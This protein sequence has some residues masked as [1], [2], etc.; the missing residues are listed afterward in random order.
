[1]PGIS[2]AVARN[3]IIPFLGNKS[4]PQVS[5]IE[6]IVSKHNQFTRSGNNL[7][8]M[9]VSRQLKLTEISNKGENNGNYPNV[10]IPK[11]LSL[12]PSLAMDWLEISWDELEMKERVGAGIFFP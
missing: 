5:I 9:D 3:S 8:E 10:A 11:Y 6:G 4:I 1:M 12:E 2:D 7:S